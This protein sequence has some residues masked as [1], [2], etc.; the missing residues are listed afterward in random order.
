VARWMKGAGKERRWLVRHA[1]RTAVKRGDVGA[2][3]VL[4]YGRAVDV[5]IGRVRIE[6]RC[7][8]I[9]GEVVIGF[10]LGNTHSRRQRLM[11]DMRL[12]FVKAN[13]GVR[14]KVFKIREVDLGAGER[15]VLAKKVSLAE[16]TTRKHYPGEHAIELLMNGEIRRLGEF[17]LEG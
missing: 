17:V 12:H 7:P 8:V 11:V 6:P 1:L 15:V 16:M 14:A 2:L 3:A 9:G 4:G 5:E 10:E 13:G